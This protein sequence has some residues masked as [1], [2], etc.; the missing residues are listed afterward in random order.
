MIVDPPDGRFPPL[1]PAGEFAK[2][3][4]PKGDDTWPRALHRLSAPQPIRYV[5]RGTLARIVLGERI[6]RPLTAPVRIPRSS[7]LMRE[8]DPALAIHHRVVRVAGVVEHQFVT[9]IE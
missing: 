3:N 4:R 9:P 6:V 5:S 8:P 7:D 1:T 2:N